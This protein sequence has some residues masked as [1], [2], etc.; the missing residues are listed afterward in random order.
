MRRFR[1]MLSLHPLG[2]LLQLGGDTV[3]RP[4]GVLRQLGVLLRISPPGG[5]ILLNLGGGIINEFCLGCDTNLTITFR[6]LHT[7][8]NA[9]SA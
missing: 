6:L 7:F 2:H 1:H 3:P 5:A 8:G 4:I 9:S